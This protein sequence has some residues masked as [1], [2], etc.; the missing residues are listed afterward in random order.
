MV[1]NVLGRLTTFKLVQVPKA[2]IGM[3]VILCGM[4]IYSR[5]VQRMNTRDPSVV[6]P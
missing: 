4:E 3:E 1:F 6:I 2:S 5:L